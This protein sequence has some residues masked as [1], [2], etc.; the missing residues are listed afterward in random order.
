MNTVVKR[1]WLI[2]MFDLRYD[3]I[4]KVGNIFIECTHANKK[5]T[6][7]VFLFMVQIDLYC[8]QPGPLVDGH[9]HHERSPT[10]K[11][12]DALSAV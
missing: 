1:L 12:G 7:H 5:P 11:L 4:L 2:Y 10:I 8:N 3:S 6:C 9:L